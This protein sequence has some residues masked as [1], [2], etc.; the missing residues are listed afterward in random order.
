[1][2][3]DHHDPAQDGPSSSYPPPPTTDAT[4]DMMTAAAATT[5][6]SPEPSRPPEPTPTATHQVHVGEKRRRDEASYEQHDPALLMAVAA[7]AR[8]AEEEGGGGREAEVH[9]QAAQLPREMS[10][11]PDLNLE[12][13]RQKRHRLDEEQ[14]QI[15][16]QQQAQQSSQQHPTLL[17]SPSTKPRGRRAANAPAEFSHAIKTRQQT[18]TRTG[19]ACDRCKVRQCL[20]PFLTILLPL[21][22]QRN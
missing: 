3:T 6:I 15:V 5:T 22:T 14:I 4:I 20:P 1:M 17:Q 2:S 21:P 10:S 19:Q 8:R 11:Y 13:D 18:Y 12:L 9:Q 7:D 16:Q